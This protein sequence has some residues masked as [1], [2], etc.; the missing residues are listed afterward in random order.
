MVAIQNTLSLEK[1]QGLADGIPAHLV[2]TVRSQRVF[3]L[4]FPVLG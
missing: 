3:L 4:C 2:F 1:S